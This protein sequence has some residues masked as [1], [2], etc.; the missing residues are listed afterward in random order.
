MQLDL[1]I[2]V[3]KFKKIYYT[4]NTKEQV[5]DYKDAIFYNDE[6]KHIVKLTGYLPGD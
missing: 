4:S 2:L 5:Q 3:D 6:T 1:W